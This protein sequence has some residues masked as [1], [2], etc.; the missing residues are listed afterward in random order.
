V[1][2][3]RTE[4]WGLFALV[5]GVS[6]ASQ[7]WVR[8]GQTQLGEELA[9]M[10]RP[11]DIQMFSSATCGVCI[12]ARLWF[13]QHQVPFSECLIEKDAACRAAFEASRAPGTPLIMVRGQPQMGF[14]AAQLRQALKAAT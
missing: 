13:T 2:A 1:K 7:A 3:S 11:G 5:L 9:R 6:L 8:Q 10:A 4:L 14:N 12:E